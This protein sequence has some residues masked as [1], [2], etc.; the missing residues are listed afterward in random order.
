MR[1]S[2]RALAVLVFGLVLAIGLPL[3][4][5]FG[6]DD[7]APVQSVGGSAAQALGAAPVT[8]LPVVPPA[9]PAAPVPSPP[10]ASPPV[11][12]PAAPVLPPPPPVG[13]GSLQVR[14]PSLDVTAQVVAVGVDA[15]GGMEIPEDVATVGWYRFGP[16]PGSAEGSTVLTGHVDDRDQGPG[17]F[18]DLK[19]V[20]P[21]DTVEVN[22]PDGAVL[23]YDVV[24]REAFPKSVVPLDRVFDR[25]GP[26]RLVLVTCGGPFDQQ[27]RNYLENIVVTAVPS[28]GR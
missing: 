21:G 23:T 2:R 9:P 18:F 19:S 7:T 8:S 16:A 22:Q 12:Q 1:S 17:A 3:G 15:D 5:W 27:T 6:R 11:P 26:P 20:E 24:A 14:L 28:G 4:W 13:P 25:D 10:V